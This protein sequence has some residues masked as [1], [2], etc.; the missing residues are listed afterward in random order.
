MMFAATSAPDS[1]Q[2][3][4]TWL[5]LAYA[6]FTR[7]VAQRESANVPIKRKIPSPVIVSGIYSTVARIPSDCALELWHRRD[8][9]FS[10]S[11]CFRRDRISRLWEICSRDTLRR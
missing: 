3:A 6:D 2:E 7:I 11:P 4:G 9:K 8:P 5:N 10:F 1:P